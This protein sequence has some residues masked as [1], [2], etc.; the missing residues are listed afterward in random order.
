MADEYQDALDTAAEEARRRATQSPRALP[1]YPTSSNEYQNAL[2]AAAGQTTPPQPNVRAVEYAQRGLPVEGEQNAPGFTGAN[3]IQGTLSPQEQQ[4]WAA[5]PAGAIK[6][7]E[8]G[9]LIGLGDK[10]VQPATPSTEATGVAPQRAPTIDDFLDPAIESRRSEI[11]NERALVMQHLNTASTQRSGGRHGG[12]SQWDTEYA[13]LKAL[14]HADSVLQKEQF[15]RAH[16]KAGIAA[17]QF[18]HQQGLDTAKQ[19]QGFY[20]AMAQVRSPIGTPEHAQ[21]VLA[22]AGQFPLAVNTPEIKK[23][24]QEH[25][26]LH[27]S[28]SQLIANALAQGKI[29]TQTGISASG[30]PTY[31]ITDPNIIPTQAQNRYDRLQASILQHQEQSDAEK[32]ANVKGGKANVPYSKA[33]ALHADQ[34]EAQRLEQQYPGLKPQTQA[35]P[36]IATPDETTLRVRHPNGTIG[37]IP[38]SQLQDALN[39]GYQRAE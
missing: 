6:D 25:A 30:K 16:I 11:A 13:K 27:D 38:A 23:V 26:D 24:L 2:S 33:P 28:H 32:Q 1:T 35:A 29:V 22:I 17:E 5:N 36:A 14:D 34:L 19:T 39:Q 20:S 18:K 3:T 10:P 12:P 8:T 31:K 4:F 7:P 15:N 21:E 37:R 9:A